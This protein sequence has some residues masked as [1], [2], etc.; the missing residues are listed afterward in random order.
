MS[1]LL[2]K[3]HRSRYIIQAIFCI[4]TLY[5]CLRHIFNNPESSSPSYTYDGSPKKYKTKRLQGMPFDLQAFKLKVDFLSED[6]GGKIVA[7]S[8]DLSHM[9]SIQNNDPNSYLLAPCQKT[10]WFIISFPERISV[11]HI[12]FVSYEYYASTYKTIRISRSLVYPTETWHTL[13]EVEMEVSQS[14]VFD[15]SALCDKG[16]NVGCWAKYLKVELLDFHNFEDNY[17]CSLTSMKVYGSTAVDVLESEIT[18]AP[19]TQDTRDSLL[20]DLQLETEI[21]LPAI[22]IG[23]RSRDYTVERHGLA[24]ICHDCIVYGNTTKPFGRNCPTSIFIR[25][26]TVYKAFFQFMASLAKR[27]DT[28][29]INRRLYM[30]MTRFIDKKEC[31][32]HGLMSSLNEKR[33]R[34]TCNPIS[35]IRCW[36]MLFRV[37]LPLNHKWFEKV[38]YRM[39]KQGWINVNVPWTFR[40]ILNTPILVCTRRYGFLGRFICFYHFTYKSFT[41]LSTQK[42]VGFIPTRV[43]D[44]SFK[45]LYVFFSDQT[46]KKFAPVSRKA[47]TEAFNGNTFVKGTRFIIPDG[48][49]SSIIISRN[50][51]ALTI[52]AHMFQNAD[53]MKYVMDLVLKSYVA[54]KDNIVS[55][56]TKD[57]GL[58]RRIADSLNNDMSSQNISL[59]TLGSN[60]RISGP[61]GYKHD[62][63]ESMTN[64]ARAISDDLPDA[65][66][67]SEGHEHVLLQLSQRVKALEMVANKLSKKAKQ[68]DANTAAFL[69]HLNYLSNKMQ[70]KKCQVSNINYYGK[71]FA[72]EMDIILKT[73]GVKRFH[74]VYLHELQKLPF[75]S[76]SGSVDK[77]L[78]GP[79]STCTIFIK[80]GAPLSRDI[81]QHSCNIDLMMPNQRKGICRMVMPIMHMSR[82]M[83]ILK[84]LKLMDCCRRYGCS[85]LYTGSSDTSFLVWMPHF[86][87]GEDTSCGCPLVGHLYVCISTCIAHLGT[88]L[89]GYI[90]CLLGYILNV[91]TLFT[92]FVL[93]QAFWVYRDRSTRALLYN[94]YC[95]T[96]KCN[97]EGKQQRH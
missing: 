50:L 29:G 35:Y 10:D 82:F 9:K 47:V 63:W 55:R 34:T 84:R 24:R 1:I 18:D 52:N 7:H 28:Y 46:I 37:Q 39:I 78:V 58:V 85:C 26:R 30:R 11:K 86:T 36:N 43:P 21:G 41:L 57:L 88:M 45:C 79:F 3:K 23:T 22:N 2:K 27:K 56:V 81:H 60:D 54:Y 49:I 80:N 90:N 92:C 97:N 75:A 73:L 16:K 53:K 48:S 8:K 69:E 68:L 19:N 96:A 61:G 6:A 4:L 44:L 70:S 93:T 14:E 65:F 74:V 94:L 12:A 25:Q 15:V 87:R 13:A 51:C 89:F 71:H 42:I 76:S 83:H 5:G 72:R 32:V 59:S 77:V 17:Y 20:E 31:G 38:I 33:I 66:T 95:H 62:R 91:Y 64:S 67:R 40:G